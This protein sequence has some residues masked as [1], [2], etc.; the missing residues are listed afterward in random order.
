MIQHI[1]DKYGRSRAGLTATV[2]TYR[3]RSAI[4][5][6]SK[7]LG[8]SEDIGGALAGYVWGASTH[9]VDIDQVR[10]LGFDPNDYRLWLALRL[11]KELVGFPRHLS[12]HPGGFAM[13]KRPLCELVPIANGA[14]EDRTMIEWD[15]DDIDALGILKVDV[16][17]L[18][19]LT[20]I[21]KG[22]RS[23][24]RPSRPPA[25]PRQRAAGGSRGLR[26]AVF[27][28]FGRRVPGRKSRSD[29]DAAAPQ[30]A[31]IL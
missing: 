22:V 6:V 26:H 25:D 27:G 23:D 7:A 15:K 17:G 28:R 19:M 2:I 10:E 3:W 18:G 30:A 24:R 14:M 8:L 29:D 12:Q 13:T 9:G 31:Q 1:Y 21:R 16:L 20:C 4:R 11:A 5:E